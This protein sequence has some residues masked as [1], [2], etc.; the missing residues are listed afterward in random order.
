MTTATA[1]PEA[2]KMTRYRYWIAIVM[3][4]TVGVSY[5]DR[6]NISILIA[7]ADF[8]D[9][10][11]IKD[12]A[13]QKGLLMSAFLFAYAFAN[14]TLSPVADIIGARKAICIGILLWCVSM[15]LGGVAGLFMVMLLSRILLGLGEG[16]QYPITGTVVKN[17]FPKHE[18]GRA[19][20]VW[21][22]GTTLAPA[23]AMPLFAWIVSTYSW[24]A[25]FWVCLV[26]NVIALYFVWAHTTDQPRDCK[27]VSALELEF[28][29]GGKAVDSGSKRAATA[30]PL[31]TRLGSFMLDYRYWLLVA[32][33]IGLMLIIWGLLTWLPS[34]LKEGRG[35]SWATMGW[36]S[37]LPFLLGIGVKIMAG[38][39]IDATRKSAIFCIVATIGAGIGIYLSATVSN[40]WTSAIL[41]CMAQ[42]FMYMGA[43]ASWTLLQGIVP[44]KSMSTAGGFMIG[45]STIAGALSPMIIGYFVS[46]TG[47]YTGALYF[48]VA[49]AVFS[50]V[51]MLPLIRR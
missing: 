43:P 48:L 10:M 34:Y 36:L 3:M 29:E 4:I 31:L 21:G 37:S 46:L 42:G 19:N 39:A 7:N 6:V 20:A 18:R 50:S 15:F 8:L 38:W 51:I 47:G 23:M 32:W 24:H 9:A 45:I 35:F 11:G 41:I 26:L 22:V 17:W 5:I 2:G 49:A 14:F 44:E 33:Y 30:E 13:I 12:Q 16:M 40:N 28:I 27:H 1:A 25:S